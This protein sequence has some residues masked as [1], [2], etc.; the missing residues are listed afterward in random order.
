MTLVNHLLQLQHVNRN[1]HFR[2]WLSRSPSR[3]NSISIGATQHSTPPELNETISQL[4]ISPLN[5]SG[6]NSLATTSALDG[7][8]DLPPTL[9]SKTE[10]SSN[11]EY[12]KKEFTKGN[13]FDFLR[14][15]NWSSVRR[16]TYQLMERK[17]T[18]ILCPS[19][20]FRGIWN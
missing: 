14:F 3:L 6:G 12:I 10:L 11:S 5:D 9:S 16:I 4:S 7:A 15:L 19:T 8:V 20:L 18:R 13:K 1:R 2:N 17:E